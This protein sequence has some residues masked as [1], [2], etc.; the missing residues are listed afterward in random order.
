[1]LQPF[2][3][4]LVDNPVVVQFVHRWLAWVVA[5][6]ALLL[7]VFAWDRGH[8]AAAASVFLTL[9]VQISLG[10]ATL[11]S[12]VEFWMAVAHQAMAAL[13]LGAIVVAAHGLGS[14]RPAA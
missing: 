11:M 12:G 2:L 3:A 4:N 10:I 14:A 1:M 6:F 8:H 7:T 13:L 9:T 5:A